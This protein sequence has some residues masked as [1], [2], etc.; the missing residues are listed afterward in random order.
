MGHGN[1]ISGLLVFQPLVFQP[2]GY[3]VAYPS[4]NIALVI[5]QR[6]IGLAAALIPLYFRAIEQELYTKKAKEESRHIGTVG[7][8]ETFEMTCTRIHVTEPGQWG[9]TYIVGM[10]EGTGNQ[11]VWFA[12]KR[13][14]ID[15]INADGSF[16]RFTELAIGDTVK[17]KATVKTQGE[18]NGYPQT[19]IT[20]AAIVSIQPAE[21]AEAA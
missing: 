13:P 21:A 7:K 16:S 18:Y 20:R 12:S 1:T 11:V 15:A 2:K 8:R 4:P 17:L 6:D 3:Q 5:S 14:G 19:I 10:I 9:S